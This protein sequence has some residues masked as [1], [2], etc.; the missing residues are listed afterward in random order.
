MSRLAK[1]RK[2]IEED[3]QALIHFNENPSQEVMERILANKSVWRENDD[4]AR[5]IF[6]QAA[7]SLYDF[8]ED[9]N[10]L[11][12]DD[13]YKDILTR[14]EENPSRKLIDQTGVLYFVS[15][16][17]LFLEHLLMVAGMAGGTYTDSSGKKCD[18]RLIKESL[19]R[20][21]LDAYSS[22]QKS[23][24]RSDEISPDSLSGSYIQS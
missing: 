15:G 16:M 3:R 5:D 4:S 23:Y 24:G 9:Q 17:E 22:I 2:Q 7:M 18:R 8:S 1:L 12:F 21:A 10:L 19:R 11:H 6:R 20:Y 14:L 13:L